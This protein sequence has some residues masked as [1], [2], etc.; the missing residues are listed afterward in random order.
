MK[1][2]R[3]PARGRWRA[4]PEGGGWWWNPGREAVLRGARDFAEQAASGVRDC[5][6][7]LQSIGVDPQT[8]IALRQEVRVRRRARSAVRRA[9]EAARRP[10]RRQAVPGL[11]PGLLRPGLTL[12]M[13]AGQ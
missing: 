3:G 12:P 11:R 10:P 13:E 8:S 6:R 9:L 7:E 4:L 5:L 2:G 1:G